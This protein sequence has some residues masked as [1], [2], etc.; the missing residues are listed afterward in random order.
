M[1]EWAIITGDLVKTGGMDRANYALAD[2]LARRGNKTHLIAFRAADELLARPGMVLHRVSKPFGS[3][4]AALPL[5]HRAGRRLAREISARGG[6][7]VVNGGSSLAHDIN[8]VHYVH[9]AYEP[10]VASS[11]ARRIATRINRRRS[12]REE[13]ESLHAARIVI[14]NS[15]RTAKDLHELCNIPRERIHTIYY[16]IDADAFQPPGDALRA[17]RR[18]ALG[19]PESAPVLAFIGAMSDR[20]KGF[21]TLFEAWPAICATL[22]E[23]P[24]LLV[25]GSGSET[26][27]WQ[28]RVADAEFAN[29]RFLGHR[30]DVSHILQAVDLLIAPTR[31]EAYGLGVHEA[32][33]CGGGAIV[34]AT[35]GVAERFPVELASLL[36]SDPNDPVELANKV[37][38]WHLH[39]ST[40]QARFNQLA[41]VFR[42]RSWD[43]MAA[44]IVQAAESV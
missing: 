21:D 34:T 8:W 20:R 39:R 1:K 11:I 25:I 14:A 19:I 17:Q 24:K 44:H 40:F 23:Q 42:R 27:F 10:V 3:Y 15:N 16:G 22:G 26:K 36:L 7:I 30:A 5:L 37:G 6:R 12:L 18:A 33:C 41:E 31:Y 13:R 32:I 4:T 28:Q 9:A 2:Y 38:Q 35:A 29:I 43:D